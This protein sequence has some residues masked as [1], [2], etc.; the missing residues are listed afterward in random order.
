MNYAR[1]AFRGAIV[2]VGGGFDFAP[3][4]GDVVSITSTTPG[5]ATITIQPSAGDPVVLDVAI[6]A[7]EVE[8]A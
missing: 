1:V 2:A 7:G 5:W 6:D 3:W 8:G 4:R